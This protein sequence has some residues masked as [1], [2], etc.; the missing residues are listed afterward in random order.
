[1]G[2]VLRK[3]EIVDGMAAKTGM[4]KNQSSA[5]F[6]AAL[7]TIQESL[8]DGNRVVV[9]GWGS[10]AVKEVAERTMPVSAVNSNGPRLVPAHN[11]VL[12]KPGKKLVDAVW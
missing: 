5:A 12:F 11:R 1:M 4:S 7:A 8:M 3:A 9:T 2:N 10:F 6:D